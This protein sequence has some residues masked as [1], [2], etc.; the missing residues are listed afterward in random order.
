MIDSLFI[1]FKFTNEIIDRAIASPAMNDEGVEKSFADSLKSIPMN[2]NKAP[3]ASRKLVTK[4][5]VKKGDFNLV[6]GKDGGVPMSKYEY[7]TEEVEEP[8]KGEKEEEVGEGK[9]FLILEDHI[10]KSTLPSKVYNAAETVILDSNKTGKTILRSRIN[11]KILSMGNPEF[12]DIQNL[13]AH[14]LRINTKYSIE[15]KDIKTNGLIFWKKDN[16]IFMR[17]NC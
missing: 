10:P 15:V 16:K 11:E 14:W 8:V 9:Y 1:G 5:D 2:K 4:A 13:N 6:N 17:L 12:K 7:K 3:P